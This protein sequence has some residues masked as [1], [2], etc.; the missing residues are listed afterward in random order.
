MSNQLEGIE[1]KDIIKRVTGKVTKLW[2]AKTFNGPKGEFTKQGGEIEIDGTTY[3]LAF[4]NNTQP[5]SLKNKVVVL[6]SVRSK[7]GLNGVTLDHESYDGKNGHVDRDVIKVTGSGKIE[8]EGQVSE[9]P[10]RLSSPRSTEVGDPKKAIQSIVDMHLYIN[11]VV[12]AAYAAKVE[13]EETMRTYVASVFIEANRKGI[14]YA[15]PT[16]PAKIDPEDWAT[17]LVPSGSMKGKNLGSVGKPALIK[18]YHHYW[19]AGFT[20]P[21]AK[22]VEQAGT[23]LNLPLPPEDDIPMDDQPEITW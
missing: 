1:Q 9:E 16:Q 4:W 13:D 20:S 17:F 15:E 18:F 2:E 21:F 6:S 19:K 8:I 10:V 14:V 3:G 11:E 23:D 22:A 7:H 12:R 5:E